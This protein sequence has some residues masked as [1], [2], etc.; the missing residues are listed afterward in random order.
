M[1]VS[2]QPWRVL[3]SLIGHEKLS[4]IYKVRSM[5]PVLLDAAKP[6]VS[7]SGLSCRSPRGLPLS[8]C[9][10]ITF[11]NPGLRL[12]VVDGDLSQHIAAVHRREIDIAFLP[13]P[14]PSMLSGCDLAMLWHEPMAAAVPISHR[15][16]E[17]HLIEWNDL[18]N[19]TVLVRDTEVG[20]LW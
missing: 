10:N 11:Q 19:E 6:E 8:Y 18:S 5:K 12:E 2:L 7:K 17:K 1:A 20:R 4:K 13:N 16:S 9:E 14:T 3:D 15:L